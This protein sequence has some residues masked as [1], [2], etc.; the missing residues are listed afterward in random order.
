MMH[1]GESKIDERGR[2]TLPKSFR[3]A[4]NIEENSTVYIQTIATMDNGVRIV[5]NPVRKIKCLNKGAQK[6]VDAFKEKKGK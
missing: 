3:D 2:I 4:N 1:I 6:V 5:F